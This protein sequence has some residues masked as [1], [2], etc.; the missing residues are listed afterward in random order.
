MPRQSSTVERIA[1]ARETVE[2]SSR[3][4]GRVQ[5][6]MERM[7]RA[8]QELED[9]EQDHVGIPTRIDYVSL[10][11]GGGSLDLGIKLALPSARCRLYVEIEAACCEILVSR[12]QDGSLDSA[13]LWSD[14][15]TFDARPWRGL[16]DMVVG[17]F[18][19]QDISTAGRGEGIQEGNRS[20]LW[21][22]FERVIRDMGPR[23][24]FVENVPAITLRGLDTVLGGL[25]ELGYSACWQMLSASSVGASHQ[26][27]RFW[28]LAHRQDGRQ[29]PQQPISNHRGNKGRT[30]KRPLAGASDR[31]DQRDT[32]EGAEDTGGVAGTVAN[33]LADRDRAGCSRT[34]IC[35][36][37]GGSQPAVPDTDGAGT[38]TLADPGHGRE[39]D[40]ARPPRR[41]CGER[42][43]ERGGSGADGGIV[44]VHADNPGQR[45]HGWPVA[46][47]TG[48]RAAECAG[49]SDVGDA[50]SRGIGPICRIQRN[51]RDS[52]GETWP[53]GGECE[54]YAGTWSGSLPLFPP[55]PGDRAAWQRILAVRPDLA[56]AVS[57]EEEEAFA[58]VR[59][60]ADGLAG[61]VG[62]SRTDQLR[63]LGNGVVPLACSVALTLLWYRLTGERLA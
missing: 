32:S 23:Y 30:R 36:P 4:A 9:E 17:G 41:P 18:P 12:M 38:G 52:N 62:L 24:V 11:S 60:V 49:G 1:A 53:D 26:R 58:R 31:G 43:A 33:P 44:V 28:L 7:V 29:Q 40:G 27:K 61:G 47:A 5:M 50:D 6:D 45:E 25:A 10:C 13:P 15:K 35:L 51:D 46:S 21:F 14:L 20:G 37:E 39:P 57:A 22:D 8:D 19:C 42:I 16:V 59:G 55:G 63:A 54:M 48:Q 2:L 3:I 34:R 56:P